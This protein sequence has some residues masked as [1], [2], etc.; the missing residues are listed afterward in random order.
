MSW[1][2]F[3]LYVVQGIYVRKKSMRL[4]P[5]SGPRSGVVGAG[6]PKTVLLTIGD[7]S[8]AAVGISK[9]SGAVGPQLAAKINAQTG[10]TVSWHISGHNS[11][12][13]AEVRDH[14]VSNLEPVEY[15]HIVIMAG[16]NDMKNWHTVPRFKKDFGS[17]LY[18]LRARFPEAKMYWHQGIDVSKCP[19][20]PEPLGSIMNL[21][22]GLFNRKGAQLCLERGV[23]CVPPLPVVD[24][25]GFCEDGFHASELGYDAWA[26]HLL[27]HWDYDPHT[28][29]AVR[30]LV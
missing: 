13:S 5:A 4:S 6:E 20:L 28:S 21:R 19:A 15:T 16:I 14:V 12:V 29:P 2:C 11:A 1:L 10:E 3:P 8:A 24:P 18:A 30:D 23:V 17:L 26:D 22:V 7:S 27:A 25:R 9:T